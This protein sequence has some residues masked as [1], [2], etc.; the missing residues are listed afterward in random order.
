MKKIIVLGSG[1]VGSVMATDLAKKY[2]VTSV[3]ISKK[4]LDKI[5]SEKIN[6]ICADVLEKD[7]LENLI[8][9]FDLQ[10]G[11]YFVNIANANGLTITTKKLLVVK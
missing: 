2:E 10:S 3:D 7:V 6:K 8:K 1:L 4:N 9:N 11:Q 5:H